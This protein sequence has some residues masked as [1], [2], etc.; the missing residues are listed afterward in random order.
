[1]SA[2]VARP[3]HPSDLQSTI[4]LLD[5]A[6]PLE[7]ITDYPGEVDL[8][9]ILATPHR[10][11]N[12]R[13]WL[14][15]VGNMVGFALVDTFHNIWFETIPQARE[16][17]PEMITWACECLSQQLHEATE[18]LTLDTNC[19][20]DYHE[21]VTLLE[22]HG[23]RRGPLRTLHMVRAL[24]APIV[25]PT[26]PADLTV[27]SVTGEHEAESLAALHRAAFGTDYMTVEERLAIMHT[28][29]AACGLLYVSNQRR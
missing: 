26:L 8:R 29:W 13:L 20:L 27:R 2:F 22:Q 7:R 14:D 3:Y 23:F 28:G 24:T 5:L 16:I 4:E 25:V 6:R 15:A 9:E 11:I 10:R 12:T 17:E 1:M 18:P 19:R 21:R